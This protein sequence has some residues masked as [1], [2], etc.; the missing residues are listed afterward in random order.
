VCSALRGILRRLEQNGKL[1]RFVI[2][3]VRLHV[4]TSTAMCQLLP[5]RVEYLGNIHADS[6]L[7]MLAFPCHHYTLG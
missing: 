5:L 4:M 7:G 3:E 1:A 2:D 6:R